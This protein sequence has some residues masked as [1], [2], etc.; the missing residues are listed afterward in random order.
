MYS[1][2][3]AFLQVVPSFKNIERA[4]R[5]EAEKIGRQVDQAISK[6]IPEGMAE[7]AKQAQREAQQEGKKAGE[8]YAGAFAD[9]VR[10]RL[11][12]ATKSLPKVEVDV[13]VDT[14]RV[15]DAVDEIRDDLET[16]RDAKIGVD[17]DL[18][19]TEFFEEITRIKRQ[20][21]ELERDGVSIEVRTNARA[22][23]AEME[24]IEQIARDDD[25]R[26]RIDGDRYGGA[27]AA[28]M[29]RR[30]ESALTALG[31]LELDVDATGA[32]AELANIGRRIR[33]L[34]E[35]DI[36][37]DIP[38]SQYEGELLALQHA[39]EEIER[40]TVNIR[41][42]TNARA[43]LAEIRALR[44]DE[45]ED[46]ERRGEVDGARYGGA[47]G[48]AARRRIEAAMQAIGDLE[49]DAD[50]TGVDA[51]LNRIRQR[52][53]RLSEQDIDVDIPASQYMAEID[54]LES[55]L[56]SI[57]R[58]EVNIR[59]RTNARQA[60]AEL[61]A[62]RQF[63]EGDRDDARDGAADGAQYGGAFG[64]AARRAISGAL[65]AL[66][67]VEFRSDMSEPMREIAMLRAQ[68]AGLSQV[69]V[70]IDMDA[71]TLF[72]QIQ[73]VE[74][75]LRELDGDDVDIDVHTNLL[76]AA[77][78]LGTVQALVNRL[79]GQEIDI[80]V[81]VD[82]GVRSLRDLAENVG[83]SMSRL[84]FLVS[85]GAS[86]GTAIVPAAAAAAGAISAIAAAASAAVI[87]VGVFALALSGVFGAVKALNKFQ[88]DQAKSA[89]SVSA[90]QTQVANSL[91]SVRSA[92]RSLA[93]ARE[94][95]ARGARDAARAVVSAQRQVI[96]A[97][98]EAERAQRD[99]IRAMREAQ[100]ADQDRAFSI[101]SNALAQRQA[102]LDIADAKADLDRVLSNP[103]ATEAEREQA[104]ITFEQRRL[105]LQELG[106]A[107][108]RLEAERVRVA[109]EGADN[110]VAAQERIRSATQ[111]VADAQERHALAIE[112]QTDQQRDGQRQLIESQTALARSQRS[113][114]ESY[115]GVGVAGGEALQNLQTAMDNL[116]PA[117]QRFARFLFSLK[118]EFL[119][120]RA[121]AE[122]GLLPGLEQG[123]R[124]LLPFLP[125]LEKFVGQ[126]SKAL[127]EIFVDFVASMKEP[128]WQEFFGFLGRSAVPALKGMFEFAEN[129]ARG[130]AGI[131]L[132]LSGF[133]GSVGQGMLQWSEDFARWGT[134]LDSNRG[135]KNFLAYIRE[136]TPKVLNFFGNLWDFAKKFV[137]AAAPIGTVVVDA[138]AKVF[139]WLGKLDTETWTIIIAALGGFA[140]ALLVVAA[141]TSAVSTG[142]AGAIVAAI[143]AF[144][145][146]LAFAYTKIKPF[147]EAV[148]ATFRGIAAVVTW[149][150]RE[151]FP[152][153][154]NNLM[155][156]V[157]AVRKVFVDLYQQVFVHM[158]ALIGA[159]VQGVGQV[160]TTIFG[161]MGV[162]SSRFGE[163]FDA[164]FRIFRIA[165]TNSATAFRWFYDHV[166]KPVFGAIGVAFQIFKA[167]VQVAFG[168]FQIGI[169]ISAQAF[170][171]FYNL[172]IGPVVNTLLKPAFNWL[173]DVIQT[174]VAPK[175][176]KGLELLGKA[177]DVFVA[178]TKAPIRFVIET[179]LNKG[180]LAGYNKVAKFFKVKPD[181]VQIDL[182]KG[183]AIGGA[184]FGAGTAT[185]DSILARLSRGE[186]VWTAREVAAAGGH[187][188]VYAL[189]QAV[190]DG[191]MPALARGGPVGDGFG[192]L[193][194]GLKKKA[195]D[196]FTGIKNFF[197][198]PAGALKDLLGKLVRLVPARDSQAVQVVLGMPQN[199]L[200]TMVEKVKSLFR[201]DQSEGGASSGGLG[202]SRMMDILR[203]AFPGLR[204]LSGY[205]PGS[206]TLTGNQSYHSFGRAVDVPPRMEVFDWIRQHFPESRE[207]IF[208]PASGRQI[209]NGRPHRYGE[210][211]RGQHWDHVHWAYDEGGMLPPG[212]STVYNGTGRPEPVLNDQQWQQISAMV[213]GGDQPAN[214]Y[215]FTFRDTT[216]DA[217]KLRA[218]QDRDA[219]L[220]R[221]GRPR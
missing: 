43:A 96:D 59:V 199:L 161:E 106:V 116:S 5:N 206:Y 71:A 25:A 196:A 81:D 160:W 204:L 89:K 142:I 99:L 46:N 87:G 45:A 50:A 61:R 12:T 21:A 202:W 171:N 172:A 3:T 182:P 135:W 112:R 189:R 129:V 133:N 155:T 75:R 42:R 79:D 110:V 198:D 132:G 187:D 2:G 150:S 205:R 188:V 194:K 207:L 51:E 159:I 123:I 208:S 107:G 38:A 152:P 183:F 92:E 113:L 20:L 94:S 22:A 157:G 147:R 220:A 149:L 175:F 140:A 111:A 167:V 128:I 9:A 88:E 26:G 70:G 215:Q 179:V 95:V 122:A 158:F 48:A 102:N 4:F 6:A 91:D 77:A 104:R 15:R 221:A 97:Q 176:K 192:D 170:R 78:E 86:V 216:L 54:L 34:S 105:Q 93:A 211:I 57:E 185:S 174:H 210:P 139:E 131:I 117:G 136:S 144:A 114:A 68:L 69:R 125:Q 154:M 14:E 73:R 148:D 53:Q 126:V 10:R 80:D 168:L 65:E 165:V 7:G 90:A 124:G 163:I 16:L 32:D 197:T 33:A 219:A 162:S 169:K 191:T 209:H 151:V 217:G 85:I 72:M 134:T 164:V 67:E 60:M 64:A 58:D 62:L 82:R 11:A 18:N 119:G 39:L 76:T 98:R 83:I 121:A 101:R 115:R 200:D 27:F 30:L 36:D 56:E 52:L 130:L 156:L 120:L 193:L 28:A 47:F 118:D 49:L 23:L 13:D 109:R 63:I 127:G 143:A 8:S 195:T 17:L 190:L 19:E 146:E 35:Q 100:E 201:G 177:W 145:T 141:V 37:V 184:V 44:G 186:H 166:L 40:D 55:V 1:A 66:P 74:A 178:A 181:D 24:A 214:T 203:G 103:R 41:I 138:F 212:W 108:K 213:R 29:R 84:G 31:D 173:A 153:A 137:I 218:L 180:I